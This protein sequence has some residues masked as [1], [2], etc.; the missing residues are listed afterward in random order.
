MEMPQ[1]TSSW[2]SRYDTFLLLALH[3]CKGCLANRTQLVD[4]VRIP[5]NEVTKAFTGGDHFKV[6]DNMSGTCGGS[7]V[8]NWSVKTTPYDI[9]QTQ[10]DA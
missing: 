3:C 4:H 8:C 2:I 10:E 9:D 1:L 7:G 6:G 5:G